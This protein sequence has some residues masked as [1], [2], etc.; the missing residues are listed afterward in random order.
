MH[1]EQIAP[2]LHRLRTLIV[3]LYFVR[4][5]TSG[6]WALVDTGMPGYA[7]AIRRAATKLFGRTRPC[8]ILLTHGHF[9]HVGN[10]AALVEEWG[11]PIF[12][13]A[14]EMPYLTGRSPYPPP[15]PTVGGG[16]V[17]WM[18]PLYPRGPFH[19][20]GAVQRLPENGVVP[21]LPEWQW[22]LTSGHAP[23]HVSFFRERDRTLLAG[24]AVVTTKAESL[25]NTLLDRAEVSRPP[26]YFTPDWSSA[27]RSVETLAALD[28]EELASGHGPM[29]R[30]PVM[31]RALHDLADRFDQVIPSSGRYV[32][33]PAVTDERGLIHVP[34]NPGYATTKATL[35]TAGVGAAVGIALIALAVRNRRA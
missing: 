22:L 14:L 4:D 28:P 34:P 26:A 17:A 33:Y 19:F 16:P 24:D 11:V 15:D 7:G 3:N 13:H 20:E 12:A 23:G 8:A 27:R 25:M 30:G 9:D 32:P 2:G 5:Q 18:S 31:R 6:E 10:L 1:A 21:A 35:A 29:V